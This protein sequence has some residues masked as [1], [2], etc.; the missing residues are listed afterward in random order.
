VSCWQA[1]LVK[2]VH[3]ATHD[4]SRTLDVVCTR[5]DLPTPVVDV[6]D[7]GLSDHYLLLWS[8]SLLRPPPAYVTSSCRPWTS[9]EHDIFHADLLA[10]A[11]CDEQQWSAI[12]GDGL[13]KRYDDTVAAGTTQDGNLPSSKVERM[14]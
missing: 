2:H 1:G 10:S 12:D 9:F 11:L 7:V 5:D 6:V 3:G 8:T 13:V 4:A 14:V